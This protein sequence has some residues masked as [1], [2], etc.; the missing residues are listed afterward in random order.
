MTRANGRPAVKLSDNP[1]KAMGPPDE[2]ARYKKTFEVGAQE[3]RPAL[4]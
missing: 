2:I 4:V 3:A 1:T